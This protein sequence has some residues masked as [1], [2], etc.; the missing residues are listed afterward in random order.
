MPCGLSLMI[1][2]CLERSKKKAT[3]AGSLT[4]ADSVGQ[5]FQWAQ[6]LPLRKKFSG[7]PPF[8]LVAT[9][10]YVP[11]WLAMRLIS[12]P[13]CSQLLRREAIYVRVSQTRALEANEPWNERLIVRVASGDP[14]AAPRLYVHEG[15]VSW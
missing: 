10:I 11:V 12:R 5:C 1:L 8:G 7:F 9:L 4:R 3:K 13:G 15:L 2:G 14:V 6:T